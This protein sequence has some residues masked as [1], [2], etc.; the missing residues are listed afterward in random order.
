[1]PPELLELNTVI[2]VTLILN[3]NGT[4]FSAWPM[5]IRLTLHE[6][7]KVLLTFPLIERNGSGVRETRI[8]GSLRTRGGLGLAER[9]LPNFFSNKNGLQMVS[10]HD[11][12]LRELCNIYR[13]AKG[14]LVKPQIRLRYS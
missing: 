11:S 12:R 1:M 10:A 7:S 13:S 8:E 4:A 14:W 2:N 5:S 3:R 9:D 6:G